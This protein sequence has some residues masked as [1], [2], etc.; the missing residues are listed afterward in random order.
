MNWFKITQQQ[1]GYKPPD[2]DQPQEQRVEPMAKGPAIDDLAKTVQMMFGRGAPSIYDD[3]GFNK[4]HYSHPLMRYWLNVGPGNEVPVRVINWTIQALVIYSKRQIPNYNDLKTRVVNEVNTQYG[5]QQAQQVQ[6]GEQPKV[7]RIGPGQFGKIEFY[8]PSFKVNRVLQVAVTNKMKKMLDAGDRRWTAG[9]NPFTHVMEMPFFKAFSRSKTKIDHYEIHPTV[10]GEVAAVLAEKGYDVSEM[11]QPAPQQPQ[12]PQTAPPTPPPPKTQPK[13]EPDEEDED[14]KGPIIQW[15]VRDVTAET[16]NRWHMGIRFLGAKTYEG[17]ALKQML[18]Y[19]FISFA[20]DQ[21]EKEGDR[22]VRKEWIV[23]YRTGERKEIPVETFVSGTYSEYI[24]FYLA[25]KN[26]NFDTTQY[27]KIVQSLIAKG[28]VKKERKKGELDGYATKESFF[29]AVEK[30]EAR[31]G[32][33]LYPEQYEGI[34]FLY[35]RQSALLGDETGVGK[36]VQTI[37]AGILRSAQSKMENYGGRTVVVTR[38]G[39]LGQWIR[40][41]AKLTGDPNAVGESPAEQKPWTV[42]YYEQFQVPSTRVATTDTLINQ[43]KNR[44]ITCLILDEIHSVKNGNPDSF[45]PSGQHK[46]KS[47][48][49]T[50]NIQEIAVHV[51]FVWG[52]SATIVANKPIDVYNQLRVI[53]HRLGQ[54]PFNRFGRE[55]GGR[56]LKSVRQRGGGSRTVWSDGTIQQQI[57]ATHRLKEALID[58]GVYIQRKKKDIRQDMPDQIVANEMIE[59]DQVMLFYNIAKRMKEY[60]DPSLAVSAMQAFRTECAIAKAPTTAKMALQTLQ[61][62]EKTAVFTDFTE[63]AETIV[64]IVQNGLDEIAKA[65]GRG[66][67]VAAIVGGMSKK[68]RQQVIDSFKD[69]SSDTRCVVINIAA[70]GTGLDFPN[71]LKD[72][73]NNDF[74]WSVALDEQALGRFYRI[75]SEDDVNVKYVIAKGTEDEEFFHK[76]ANKKK[77]AEV[78]NQLTEQQMKL[79]LRGHRKGKSKKLDEVERKLTEAQ[80]K[81]IEMEEDE[82]SF[83]RRIG[84]GIIKKIQETT[85]KQ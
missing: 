81:Q 37:V 20:Q 55:F 21:L 15:K 6:P 61:K 60:K 84:E 35:G 13:L 53:G 50:F 14:I 25:L 3:T 63:S 80:V 22:T 44:E 85:G 5:G 79:L 19:T 54:M 76:L 43:A 17:Q 26:R 10:I 34:G 45:D 32:Y 42:M 62:G 41:V 4:P 39:A 72:I 1:W 12:Q 64:R 2:P 69:K 48:H 56:V 31:A 74:D 27:V 82:G 18:R 57:E 77:I 68:N 36:T 9:V 23:D 29:E 28:L 67:R 58:Q 11:Q 47:N 46:H 52:A 30:F 65:G 7:K 24:D 51:P 40:E 38:L 75:N 33:E 66:G 73:Y 49:R 8:I 83:E 16:N 70:G 71:I 59:V 78:V